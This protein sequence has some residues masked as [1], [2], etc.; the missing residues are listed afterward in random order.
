MFN[1]NNTKLCLKILISWH[2]H[3]QQVYHDM[4]KLFGCLHKI[5][6]TSCWY[7]NG[8]FIKTSLYDWNFVRGF[9]HRLTV[10]GVR[11]C[12]IC[13]CLHHF[14]RWKQTIWY[15]NLYKNTNPQ[16]IT[17]YYTILYA[18]TFIRS[19]ADIYCSCMFF[20]TGWRTFC[21]FVPVGNKQ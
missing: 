3:I 6:Y 11:V 21:R 19:C 1:L 5:L 12:L 15:H 18:L 4:K 8:R 16:S 17:L 14:F 10:K 7:K 2:I 13:Y 20:N 9:Q